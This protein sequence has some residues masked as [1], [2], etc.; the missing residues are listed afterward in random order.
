MILSFIVWS[1]SARP[2]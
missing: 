1:L 2:D